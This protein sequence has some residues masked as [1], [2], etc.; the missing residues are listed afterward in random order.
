MTHRSKRLL[1]LSLLLL[2]GSVLVWNYSAVQ[3]EAR[4]LLSSRRYKSDVWSRPAPPDGELKH[5][6][7]DAWGWAGSDTT[8]YLVFDP[9][10]SLSLAAATHESGKFAGIPCEVPKVSRLESQW[11]LVTFYTNQ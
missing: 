5:I 11:Y 10:D 6:E 7:W 9:T 8:V 1:A 3:T 4:W 2:I